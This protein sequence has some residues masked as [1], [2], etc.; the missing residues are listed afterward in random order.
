MKLE[1]TRIALPFG[2]LLLYAHDGALCALGWSDQRD[3][4]R[5]LLERRFGSFTRVETRDPAGAVTALEKYADGDVAA[6]DDVAVD[7]GGTGFQQRVWRALRAIPVGT[8]TSY[9]ALARSLGEPRAMRAVGAANGRNP[10]P[11]VIP[12]HR[13]IASDGSLHGYGGGLDRKRMLLDHER[14]HAGAPQLV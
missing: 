11:I 3:E 10:V 2:D 12:C 8:T 9:G 5:S 13:V 4:L 7:T 6:L 14:R 1:A